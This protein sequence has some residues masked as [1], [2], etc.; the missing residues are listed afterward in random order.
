MSFTDFEI[1]WKKTF[2]EIVSLLHSHMYYDFK[3]VMDN[4][5]KKEENSLNPFLVLDRLGVSWMIAINTVE[6]FLIKSCLYV[7]FNSLGN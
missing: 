6:W 4:K 1:H 2:H 3:I 5:I 7:N